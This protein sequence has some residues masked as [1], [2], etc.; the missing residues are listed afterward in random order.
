MSKKIRFKSVQIQKK[1]TFAKF[2]LQK[3]DSIKM[4]R[5]DPC[6]CARC[7]PIPAN[8]LK[9][10][11]YTQICQRNLEKCCR[12]PDKWK[13]P[14]R[15]YQTSKSYSETRFPVQM[16]SKLST[17]ITPKL[18]PKTQFNNRYQTGRNVKANIRNSSIAINSGRKCATRAP[19]NL[20]PRK[21][22]ATP[23][24]LNRSV[25]A[26][27][28]N[29]KS[30]AKNQKPSDST[31]KS[32]VTENVI[33]ELNENSTPTDISPVVLQENNQNQEES[34][35]LKAIEQTTDTIDADSSETTLNQTEWTE[36]WLNILETSI[37][38]EPTD[39]DRHNNIDS[40]R[41]VEPAN[42]EMKKV[43]RD[44]S[45]E[46]T[47][48]E[49]IIQEPNENL[50]ITFENEEITPI[51]NIAMPENTSLDENNYNQ[52]DSYELETNALPTIMIDAH[53]NDTTLNE[54]KWP[55]EW[56]NTTENESD[57]NSNDHGND[58][59]CIS[60]IDRVS[61]EFLQS[62]EK[63]LI[64][65]TIT[66]CIRTESTELVAKTTNDF[67][68]SDIGSYQIKWV[69]E[70]LNLLNTGSEKELKEKLMTIGVKKAAQIINCRNTHGHFQQ[71]DSLRQML[72]WTQSAYTKFLQKNFLELN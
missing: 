35:E 24:K 51:K 15:K 50:R 64:K 1:K 13:T 62:P 27:S 17:T 29:Q 36:E 11:S 66:N 26:F 12:N 5:I 23:S 10:Q 32:T 18:Q 63:S 30:N 39:V 38:I 42:C 40:N 54:S 52:V 6:R 22:F 14:T 60:G 70:V 71:I 72:G 7:V 56:L 31:G 59:H 21:L 48:E 58:S 16:Q 25:P 61:L 4:T 46:S 45:V 34:F 57:C 41:I 37:Q 8:R 44:S 65:S 3:E 69:D 19:F 67:A 20:Q 53:T 47:P 9:R 55:V 49:N 43:S 28:L 68:G 2:S 33:E